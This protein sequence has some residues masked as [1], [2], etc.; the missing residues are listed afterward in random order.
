MSNEIE[1]AVQAFNNLKKELNVALFERE[2]EVQILLASMVGRQHAVLLGPPGTAKSMLINLLAEAFG[3]R[4][5]STLMTRFSEPSEVFGPVSLKA[6]EA[7]RYERKPDGFLPTAEFAF[8]DEVFKANSAIL[9]S[10]LGVMNERTW[11]NGNKQIQVPLEILV[12]ASNEFPEDESL[13]ALFDRFTYRKMV[14]GM[15]SKGN[16]VS[17]LTRKETP[18]VGKVDRKHLSVLRELASKVTLGDDAVSAMMMIHQDL[19][20]AKIAV[21][22]RRWVAAAKAVK[23]VTALRGSDKAADHDVS[24]LAHVLWDDEDDVATVQGIVLKHCDRDALKIREIKLAVQA[25][26]REID[27]DSNEV[28]KKGSRAGRILT[29]MLKE[30]GAL[31]ASSGRDELIADLKKAGGDLQKQM[32]KAVNMDF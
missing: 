8:L 25:A 21:S 2:E 32:H 5:F 15:K 29:E 4:Q 14:G 31:C 27:W 3:G 23:A 13:N 7:D 20:E 1:N 16:L 6:L 9:N 22:D 24:I 19:G 11:R 17:L 26:L 10:L 18:K 28:L 12:G 30:A